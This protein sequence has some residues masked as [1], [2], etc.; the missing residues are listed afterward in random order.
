M[1]DTDPVSLTCDLLRFNTVNPP[2]EERACAKRL[3][4]LLEDVGFRVSYY[5]F[6]EKRT[7]LVA[8]LAGSDDGLPLCFTGHMDVVPL[9]MNPW[10]H[11][12]FAG[13]RDGDRLYGRGS[14]D[15][16][17]ALAAIVRA[18]R[19]FAALP[20]RK[21]GL[22]RVFTAGEET[23]CEG[24]HITL[25]RLASQRTPQCPSREITRFIKSPMWLD[26]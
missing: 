23:R 4:R 3:G 25:R 2:G 12:P 26:S 14:T 10:R 1:P 20:K 22:V 15:M 24:S 8:T 5:E 19:H 13:E 6:A 16:K 7:S 21:A 17:G 18:A 9:G 11:D